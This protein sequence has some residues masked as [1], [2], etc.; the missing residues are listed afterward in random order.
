[1]TVCLPKNEFIA[2]PKNADLVRTFGIAFFLSRVL[3][4]TQSPDTIPKIAF[5]YRKIYHFMNEKLPTSAF[6]HELSKN[7]EKSARDG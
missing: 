4:G 3:R 7:H 2:V 6:H 1:M 5:P